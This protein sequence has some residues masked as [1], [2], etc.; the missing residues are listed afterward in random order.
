MRHVPHALSNNSVPSSAKQQRQITTILGFDDNLSTHGFSRSGVRQHY[1][2][3]RLD[4]R[5]GALCMGTHF[6]LEHTRHVL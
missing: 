1:S 6:V 2:M 5:M 4:N 3:R